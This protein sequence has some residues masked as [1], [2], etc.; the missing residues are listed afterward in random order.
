[1]VDVGLLD[2]HN[3]FHLADGVL[4]P[5]RETE[6]ALDVLEQ[7]KGKGFYPYPFMAEHDPFLAP[8]RSLPRFA[9]ILAKAKS[10]A[11]AFAASLRS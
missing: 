10:L 9:G 6:K 11:E 4:R 7:A 3:Q 5:R 1:M 8:L 2:A